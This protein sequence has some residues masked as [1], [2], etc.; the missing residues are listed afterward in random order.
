MEEPYKKLYQPTSTQE[1]AG[2]EIK[3][4]TQLTNNISQEEIEE[5]ITKFGN[6]KPLAVD[7][8]PNLIIKYYN[9][10]LIKELTILL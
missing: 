4:D 9:T 8:I 2:T 7:G 10:N 3:Y 5:T 6:R 1:D